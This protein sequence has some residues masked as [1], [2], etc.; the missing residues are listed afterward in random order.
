MSSSR[1]GLRIAATIF[2]IF[3]L[4]HLLRIVTHAR[5]LV[6][7]HE[8]PMVASVVALIIAAGLS[9]WMWSLSAQK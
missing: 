4:G 7:T 6:G 1:T 2:A 3:A 9:V 5:V 8:I